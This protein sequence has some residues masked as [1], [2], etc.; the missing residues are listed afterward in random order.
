MIRED[1]MK[2]NCGNIEK[3]VTSFRTQTVSVIF[4]TN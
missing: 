3:N 4:I 2:H 1:H